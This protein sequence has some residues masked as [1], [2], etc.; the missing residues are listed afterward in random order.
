LNRGWRFCRPLPYHLATAPLERAYA[1][2]VRPRTK[3]D[4]NRPTGQPPPGTLRPSAQARFGP[5]KRA[6][7]INGCRVSVSRFA[8][9]EA[10]AFG[11]LG[12]ILAVVGVLRRRSLRRRPA[13]TGVW[14]PRPSRRSTEGP[15][16]ILSL[17]AGLL[18]AAG[19]FVG[20]AG[21]WTL[22]GVTQKLL[23]QVTPRGPD[24]S[25]RGPAAVSVASGFSRKDA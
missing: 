17:D 19:V 6:M 4:L 15:S 2:G 13:R 18:A 5:T 8:G 16:S 9:F 14:R 21:A 20:L 25:P 24:R 12:L 3:G 10:D 23:F 11:A 7:W 22:T 1:V